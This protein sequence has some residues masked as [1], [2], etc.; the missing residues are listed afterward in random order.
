MQVEIKDVD[1]RGR[2][3]LTKDWR[4]K[5]LKG[6]KEVI[7]VSSG[8]VVRIKPYSAADFMRYCIEAD[9]SLSN[10]SDMHK[11]KK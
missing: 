2:I 1:A 7:V 4:D 11:T 8:G 10:L 9:A 6:S 5:Y 3:L